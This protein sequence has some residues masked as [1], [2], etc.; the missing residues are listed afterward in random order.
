MHSLFIGLATLLLLLPS[1][2]LFHGTADHGHWNELRGL[3]HNTAYNATEAKKPGPPI[4]ID[5][6]QKPFHNDLGFW[7]GAGEN[8]SVQRGPGFIR[9]FPTDPDQNFHTQFDSNTCYSLL[10]WYS[11]YLHVVFEGTDQFSV[12]FN[13]HND[14]CNPKRRPFPSVADSVQADR[15][16]VHPATESFDDDF[17][18]DD[19]DDWDDN[20]DDIDAHACK[21]KHKH[22]KSKG[23]RPNIAKG[24][25]KIPKGRRELYIPL[26]HFDIDFNRVVSVSFHGFYTK[27]SITL[28]RVEIVHDVPKPSREN[29]HYRLPG[30][31]PSGRLVLRCSRPNSFAFGIDDGQPQFSQRVMRILDEE[32]VRVTFFVVGAGL[33]DGSSNF[34][35]F[36][37]E[38]LK[39]GHQ[40][41]LHSNTHPK[42]ESLRSL[43][44]IDDEIIQAVKTF[45]DRLSIESSYF[46][47]PFGTVA[48]RL[49]Q[50]LARH[51]PNPYIVNWSV[52]VE[53]WLWANTSTPEKQL[54][55]FYRGVDKGGNLAVMHYLN[56]TTIGYL[57]VFIRHIKKA[58][59]RIM[60]IDQCL[61][62]ASAPPL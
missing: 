16:V 49:R 52:D 60:R 39:K 6:F 9:L 26:T 18:D 62:D 40:V 43:H 25:S 4:V 58:G 36:Y 8:L 34:T 56:P 10:P 45:K 42:M 19:D 12:S 22:G 28:H 29:G 57:P 13:Q 37:K 51:I 15:Y 5:T 61:E 14:E 33:R 55:A 54:E 41:A 31:L 48:A 50:Q 24:H 27:E 11:E 53:D 7:H 30:K 17:D 21:K 38:M 20:D 47:P 32:N 44:E 59:Y 1:S 23:S 35:E 3:T 46:R 2:A